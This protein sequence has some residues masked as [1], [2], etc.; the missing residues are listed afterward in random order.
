MR[1]KKSIAANRLHYLKATL[2]IVS[3]SMM[4]TA[5]MESL[6]KP[7]VLTTLGIQIERMNDPYHPIERGTKG[8]VDHVDDA[9]TLHCTFDT[10]RSLGVVTDADIFHVIDRLNVPVAER[11]AYL[12]GSAIDGNKRLHSV[13]EVA[14]FICKHGQYGD[15]RITTME[16]KE[17]LDTF[18]IY[19]NKISDM[20]YREELLKV[21][22]P[23]QHEVENA[24]FSE[25]ED[26]E[27]TEDVDKTM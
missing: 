11:Y 9:G 15:V 7:R 8:T 21:L 4:P 3:F 13:Q 22:V 2:H 23:M 14:E 25:D 27:E 10:V 26:M 24:A 20:E 1:S 5:A 12:L 6:L 19:I 18:G 16:G 17:L